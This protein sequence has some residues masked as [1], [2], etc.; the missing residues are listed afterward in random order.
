VAATHRYP[1]RTDL[2][3]GHVTI[4]PLTEVDWR[5]WVAE[6]QTRQPADIPR[7]R[8]FL[9]NI[10]TE[11]LTVAVSRSTA[12]PI[13]AF[14]IAVKE[15]ERA[16][17]VLR[18]YCP[19]N[20]YPS[21]P[22]YCSIAGTEPVDRPKYLIVQNGVLVS[23][24]ATISNLR[25]RHPW[26]ID[27]KL[28]KK[29]REVGFDTLANL[30]QT[31]EQDRTDLQKDFVTALSIYSKS[32]IAQ[33]LT[34]KLVYAVFTLERLLLKDS[35]EPLQKH[36]SERMAFMIGKSLPGRIDIISNYKRA[37]NLRSSAVHHGGEVTHEEMEILN[38]FMP[39]AWFTLN[40][41]V[42]AFA[43]FKSRQEML[44]FIDDIKFS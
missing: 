8:R 25:A 26:L 19:S 24:G 23:A 9:T 16:L 43:R 33:D 15:T 34:D 36:I 6:W 1:C 21:M 30:L 37:Y 12:E 44:E 11:A 29:M 14:E 22:A 5:K 20:R 41:I 40:W 17:D 3:L 27:E 7:L 13:K 42:E 38:H 32:C 4:R 10:D 2:F 18:Y 28:L 39:N 31:P 35:S